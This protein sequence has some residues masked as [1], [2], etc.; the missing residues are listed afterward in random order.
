HIK[1]VSSYMRILIN[2]RDELAWKRALGH[3]DKV[4]RVTADKIWR[5]ISAT[6]DPLKTFV[7]DDFIDK[8]GKSA[9]LGIEQCRR[10]FRD[11]LLLAPEP[12]PASVIDF[13]LKNGYHDYLLETF[14]DAQ[15]RVEDLVQFANFS[16]RFESM[17]AFLNEMAL[18]T[19]VS[20]DGDDEQTGREE[21]IVL[22]TIHQAKGLEWKVVFLIWCADGMI[23]LARALNDPDG[24]EEERR[25][26]YVATTR[27]KDHLYLSY[28]TVE[29]SRGGGYLPVRP[30]RFIK[31]LTNSIPDLEEAPYERW[32]VD[33]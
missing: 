32:F 21:S 11:L 23:P 4:G 18:L 28:P 15:G 22:S 19:G 2:P 6:A 20:A 7:S 24:E 16:S 31:E 9:R 26:F 13:I 27:A 29:Y 25:L 12:E 17:E 30:S 1:D 14:T 5:E 8:V 10:L 3:Y 33:E